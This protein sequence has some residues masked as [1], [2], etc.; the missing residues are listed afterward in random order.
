[1][2]QFLHVAHAAREHRPRHSPAFPATYFEKLP[3]LFCDPVLPLAVVLAF[4]YML[5][6]NEYA[7]TGVA[8]AL[9][10][11]DLGRDPEGDIVTIR[12]SKADTYPSRHRRAPAPGPLAL[13]LLL[14]VY[15]L[16]HPPRHGRRGARQAQRRAAARGGRQRGRAHAGAGQRRVAGRRRRVLLALAAARRRRGGARSRVVHGPP[17]ARGALEGGRL[18]RHVHQDAGALAARRRWLPGYFTPAA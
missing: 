1:V 12:R 7:Q 6:V 10:P 15:R 16:A 13:S 8:S 5:R 14:A 3:G 17:T 9:L 18:S 4:C 2:P 11:Q